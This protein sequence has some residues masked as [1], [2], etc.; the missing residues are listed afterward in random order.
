MTP[1]DELATARYCERRAALNEI[2]IYDLGHT[3]AERQATLDALG[4]TTQPRVRATNAQ[5]TSFFDMFK[6]PEFQHRVTRRVKAND[7]LAL[8][9]ALN[10]AAGVGGIGE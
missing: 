9:A 2:T 6:A 3:A 5:W 4:A 8:S 7:P 10:L 1:E